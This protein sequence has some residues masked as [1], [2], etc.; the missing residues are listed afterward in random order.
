MRTLDVVR[1][2][3]LALIIGAAPLGAAL[4]FLVT[5]GWGV[6]AAF[7]AFLAGLS[8]YGFG[9]RPLQSRPGAHRTEDPS[10]APILGGRGE[11]LAASLLARPLRSDPDRHR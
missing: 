3:Y 10:V 8:I 7:V 5:P 1:F 2:T 11:M 6:F 4:W 9:P